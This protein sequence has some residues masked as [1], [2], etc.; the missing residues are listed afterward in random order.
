MTY[1]IDSA[2]LCKADGAGREKMEERLVQ[3]HGDIEKITV[4]RSILS[5]SVDGYY[6]GEGKRYICIVAAHHALESITAN[7]AFSLIDYLMTKSYNGKIKDIDCKL[8]LL[9]YRFLVIP[10]ANPDGVELRFNGVSDSP[11]KERILRMSGGD[12]SL[13]QANARGVDLNHNYDARFMEYKIIE[14]KMGIA[15]GPTLYSGEAPESE[16]ETKGIANLIRSL[17]PSAIMSL[18]TQGEEIYAYPKTHRVKRCAHRLSSAT[19]YGVSEADG[20]AG[21]GGLCD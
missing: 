19:G 18:H 13:W 17:A 16:P 5:R 20:T 2:F 4:A 14:A 7:F 9:K 21:Y 6:I 8:L 1:K 15:A 11:L 12:F 10:C 3:K